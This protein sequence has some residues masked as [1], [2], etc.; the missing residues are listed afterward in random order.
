MSVIAIACDCCITIMIMRLIACCVFQ[1]KFHISSI[2][3]LYFQNEVVFHMLY[4][5]HTTSSSQR[6]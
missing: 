5:V 3:Q 4:F 1:G 6:I 2:F